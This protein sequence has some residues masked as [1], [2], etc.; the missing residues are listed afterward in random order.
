VEGILLQGA[1]EKKSP[2]IHG[3][4]NA[5]DGFLTVDAFGYCKPGHHK[6]SDSISLL[7]IDYI[8]L[9][10]H[11][12][13][14][15][16]AV[17][18]S[19]KANRRASSFGQTRGRSNGLPCATAEGSA[20][21]AVPGLESDYKAIHEQAKRLTPPSEGSS[22]GAV[23]GNLHDSGS[24][25]L[26]SGGWG[27]GVFST[28]PAPPTTTEGSM[29]ASTRRVQKL[30]RIA[31]QR[32]QNPKK[33]GAV[34]A[35]AV[36]NAPL[37][38]GTEQSVPCFHLHTSSH[39]E[40][41]GRVFSFRCS[42]ETDLDCWVACIYHTSDE[43]KER[44]FRANSSHFR[45]LQRWMQAAY[46]SN[47]FQFTIVSLIVANFFV[48]VVEAETIPQGD[49]RIPYDV[50]DKVFTWIFLAELIFNMTANWFW[51]FWTSGWNMLDVLVVV[52]SLVSLVMEMGD[53]D[54]SPIP[55]VKIIRV[56]RAFRVVRVF[57]RLTS[58][59][60]IVLALG[61]SMVPVANTFFVLLLATAIY[62]ILGVGIFSD[63]EEFQNFSMAFFT[64]FQS[65]TG[66]G[67]ASDIARPMM[68]QRSPTGFEPGIAAFFLSYILIVMIVLVNIVLAVLLD[69]FLKT[70]E[71]N[72]LEMATA[73]QAQDHAGGM[74]GPLDPVL[75]HLAAFQ[76]S[77]DLS[78]RIE[79]LF[80]LLDQDGGGTIAFDEFAAGL[81]RLKTTPVIKISQ[82]DFQDITLGLKLCGP[83]GDLTREQF[84]VV[85]R[86]QVR[87]YVQ[88]LATKAMATLHSM[89]GGAGG[90][91]IVI[92]VLKFAPPC[93][94]SALPALC[95]CPC[96]TQPARVRCASA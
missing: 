89:A 92:F 54:S 39:G 74:F 70:A 60:M 38:S 28:A 57:K 13:E 53:P 8:S 91:D 1:L 94:Q 43:A 93:L 52:V 59:R 34:P 10:T 16:S 96:G 20:P 24:F 75:H 2:G 95:G 88:R 80:S 68:E 22:C 29:A 55:A 19:L 18:V 51:T 32:A 3:R 6:V 14:E 25:N 36:G 62:A 65:V 35:V 76:S 82:D 40:Y 44:D 73:K 37:V 21:T 90:N 12:G 7:E 58:L 50:L 48:N 87:L 9:G 84:Q 66:D 61:A 49:D 30:R 85:M 47:L 56:L 83:Q 17:R 15:D 42:Q 5:Y 46:A 86:H 81:R 11:D 23:I 4:W 64:M 26:R 45:R 78:V 27:A 33:S 41:S 31:T 71:Q 77:E 79:S 69:E 67:W 63:F 72:K